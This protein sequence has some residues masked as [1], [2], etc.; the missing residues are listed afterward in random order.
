MTAHNDDMD[1]KMNKKRR[2]FSQCTNKWITPDYLYHDT[3]IICVTGVRYFVIAQ[4]FYLE[5]FCG[6]GMLEWD[7]SFKS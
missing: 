6:T 5:I 4:N 3:P 7:A 1:E 2:Y